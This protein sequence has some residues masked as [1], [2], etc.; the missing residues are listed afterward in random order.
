MGEVAWGHRAR[1]AQLCGREERWS[2]TG[3]LP[4][5]IRVMARH[6][7][8]SRGSANIWP[9]FLEIAKTALQ[10][11]DSPCSVH[12]TNKAK[13]YELKNVQLLSK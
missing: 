3:M 9:V 5:V 13:H 1:W 2:V 8:S 6:G 7:R 12:S 4:G 11:M 10:E